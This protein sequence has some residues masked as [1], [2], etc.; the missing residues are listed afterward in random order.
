MPRD[1]RSLFV[2]TI[3]NR[4][5]LQRVAAVY[6]AIVT[7]L[8]CKLYA[9]DFIQAELASA[10]TCARFVSKI[11]L[12][13]DFH[14]DIAPEAAM[15]HY[16]PYLVRYAEE[17]NRYALRRSAKTITVSRNLRDNLSVYEASEAANFILP[18][19]N[20]LSSMSG[21]G[22]LTGSITRCNAFNSESLMMSITPFLKM[23]Y[24][25]KILKFSRAFSNM[26]GIFNSSGMT[27][28]L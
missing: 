2:Y 18:C 9:I 4:L 12:I 20:T 28:Y 24:C 3:P 13:T 27:K 6:R 22:P 21:A 15:D 5:H 8:V 16:A 19:L 7:W 14:S 26:L 11:P 23:R 10:A 25:S 1:I 17:E